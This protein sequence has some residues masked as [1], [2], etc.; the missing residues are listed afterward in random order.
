MTPLPAPGREFKVNC[1][2]PSHVGSREFSAPA[3]DLA[4]IPE[5]GSTV[6]YLA[7]CPQWHKV[8]VD[9][10]IANIDPEVRAATKALARLIE[11][12]RIHC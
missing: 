4:R 1:T 6:V 9:P 3:A 10:D 7:L 12:G 8:E 5:D 2:D 11:S